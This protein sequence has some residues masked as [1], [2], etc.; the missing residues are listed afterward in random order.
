[1]TTRRIVFF[2]GYC[3]ICNAFVDWLMRIDKNG[4][5]KFASLQGETAAKTFAT[6][7][8]TAEQTPAI[9]TTTIIYL[10]NDEKYDQSSA[11]LRILMD[12]GGVWKLAGI[13][14]L[15][16][17]C[18]RDFIY[19]IIANNRHRFIKPRNTCRVPTPSEQDRLLR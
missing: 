2:D 3:G 8:G 9:K 16:P 19:R 5:L 18:I 7:L 12:I 10:C 11:V 17:K 1:M 13:F 6:A 15:V 4:E 14:Y